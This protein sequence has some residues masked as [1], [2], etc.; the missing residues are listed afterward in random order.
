[1]IHDLSEFR[2]KRSVGEHP[3]KSVSDIWLL[4]NSIGFDPYVV[5]GRDDFEEV[6]KYGGRRIRED[7]ATFDPDRILRSP[8]VS[9]HV[10][11]LLREVF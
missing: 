2:L 6:L 11:A 8:A 1:M 10:K 3:P 9:N 4:L 7:Y 5:L